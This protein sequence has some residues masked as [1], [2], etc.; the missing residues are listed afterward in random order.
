MNE[1]SINSLYQIS[2]TL[3]AK[4]EDLEWTPGW[5][6]FISTAASAVLIVL[7]GLSLATVVAQASQY[8]KQKDEEKHS[9][10]TEV[11]LAKPVQSAE[12]PQPTQV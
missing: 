2:V 10:P 5:S 3:R 8:Q 7:T 6:F 1:N 12:L 11:P 4:S 9:K